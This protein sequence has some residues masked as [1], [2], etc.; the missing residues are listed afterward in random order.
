VWCTY[1]SLYAPIIALPPGT[2]LPTPESYY[3][4]F[5]G[6]MSSGNLPQPGQT[7]I[8][9]QPSRLSNGPWGWV[10]GDERGLTSDAGWGCMLRTGQSLLANALIHLHLGRGELG[11]PKV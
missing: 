8:G 10:K 2:L 5:T 3:G 9:A 11:P 1:R 6:S 4:A 7:S